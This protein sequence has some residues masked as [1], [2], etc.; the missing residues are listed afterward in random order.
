MKRPNVPGFDE[1]DAMLTDVR[2]MEEAIRNLRLSLREMPKLIAAQ[3]NDEDARI[4]AARY[5]YWMVPEIAP[6][7]ISEGLL[8]LPVTALPGRIG[9]VS[10]LVE[11]DR[12]GAPLQFRS[13]SHMQSILRDVRRSQRKGHG[14]YAEGYSVICD[15]CWKSIQQE[16]SAQWRKQESMRDARL[17]ELRTMPY[18]EYL[19]TP[20]WQA[21]RK[22]HVKSAG[23]RCQVC[24]ASDV[25]LNVHHRTYERRGNE[26]YKDLLA[27]CRDCHEIFHREGKLADD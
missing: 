19:K 11:C 1:L 27:L 9:T 26:Y 18:R 21:R 12:C 25:Q 13:R 8:G 7:T 24:N 23:F 10:G 14:Y 22:Q 4:E 5:L 17:L 16:R 20:E 3:L 15:P 6:T 2:E